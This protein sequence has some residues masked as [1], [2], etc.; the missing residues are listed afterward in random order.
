MNYCTYPV[1][2]ARAALRLSGFDVIER[3]Q[4]IKCIACIKYTNDHSRFLHFQIK[5]DIFIAQT[6]ILHK[7]MC[8]ENENTLTTKF[9]NKKYFFHKGFYNCTTAVPEEVTV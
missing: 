6:R 3:S 1:K 4:Q 7:K 9:E 2:N 5:E 8:F